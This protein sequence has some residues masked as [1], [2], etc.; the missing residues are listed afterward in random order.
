M[1]QGLVKS[2]I[3]RDSAETKR[4]ACDVD[5]EEALLGSGGVRRPANRGLHS[6]EF[7]LKEGS[8]LCLRPQPRIRRDGPPIELLAWK[9]RVDGEG[10]GIVDAI[11]WSLIGS[12]DL[13]SAR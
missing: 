12:A 10:R 13:G 2:V 9:G 5:R 4:L 7:L 3:S 6:A 11:G 8:K 1:P